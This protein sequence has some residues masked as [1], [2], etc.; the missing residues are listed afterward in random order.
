V[1]SFIPPAKIATV[2]A[3]VN[4]ACDS[5]DG[6][7]D[8]V[9]NDPRE[10]KFDPATIQCKSGEESEKCLTAGQVATLNKL[11][12][13]VSDSQG[14]Q[15]FPGYLPGA[16]EGPGGWGLWITGR[17]P[18]TSLMASFGKG[19]FSNFVYEKSDWDFKTFN[20]D[21]GLK[22]ADEKTAAALNAVDPD[23]KAFKT[24]GGKLILYHGWNDPAIP[25]LNTV[26]YYESVIL[27]M[28]LKAADSFVKL[29]MVPGMQHCGGGPGAESFGGVGFLVFD[30]PQHSVDAALEQWVEKG[31]VPGTIIA[32][33]YEG[34]DR[35]QAKMTRPL[36]VYP[37]VAKYKGAGDT[38][39]AASFSCQK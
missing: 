25:S 33:K 15:L 37:Q 26:N 7:K 10:C 12:S 27:K 3:A 19:F 38:N 9:L 6:V 13:G 18:G 20:V 28:G 31:T 36:C 21:Q 1:E 32:S 23:L 24:R 2:A 34:G 4:E 39:D 22:A 14:N 8:G 29:Y 35:S 17:A 16:E 11:Y 5:K 30:D